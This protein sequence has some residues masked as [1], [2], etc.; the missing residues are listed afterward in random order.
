MER[1]LII[2][3]A[4]MLFNLIAI[5]IIINDEPPLTHTGF[6]MMLL[7]IANT[8][9]FVILGAIIVEGK[10]KGKNNKNKIHFNK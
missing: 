10:G 2:A 1:C 7:L 5:F 9:M 3:W 6:I 4:L 8:L